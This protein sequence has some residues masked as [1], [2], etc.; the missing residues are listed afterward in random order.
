MLAVA[1]VRALLTTSYLGRRR[2]LACRVMIGAGHH[3][4][5][6]RTVLGL[7]G[8]IESLLVPESRVS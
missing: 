1:G 7:P 6:A 3:P 2:G 5:G 8:A 4:A